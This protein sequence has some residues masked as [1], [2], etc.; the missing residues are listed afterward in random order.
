MNHKHLLLYIHFYY[1]IKIFQNFNIILF[2]YIFV[3]IFHEKINY[4][5]HQFFPK[6]IIIIKN[7]SFFMEIMKLLIIILIFLILEI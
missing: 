1:E 5:L 4:I 6:D 3:K 7:W 2:E